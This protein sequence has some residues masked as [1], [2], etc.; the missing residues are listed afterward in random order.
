MCGT[1]VVGGGGVCSPCVVIVVQKV[2]YI[3]KK[4]T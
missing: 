4:K 1:R 2:C 3:K